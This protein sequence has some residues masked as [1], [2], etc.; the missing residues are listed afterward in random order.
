M[1]PT[2]STL[3]GDLVGETADGVRAA[4]LAAAR[5][6]AELADGLARAP[7]D[8][9]I[10]EALAALFPPLRAPPVDLLARMLDDERLDAV[11]STWRPGETAVRAGAVYLHPELADGTVAEFPPIEREL[12]VSVLET[13]E[14]GDGVA[15]LTKESVAVVRQAVR[16]RLETDR[17]SVEAAFADGVPTPVVE[18]TTVEAKAAFGDG[19][20]GIEASLP[21]D[22]TSHS[23]RLGSVRADLRFVSLPL[24]REDYGGEEPGDGPGPDR[25][26]RPAGR[27]FRPTVTSGRPQ[28]RRRGTDATHRR[29][30]RG[31]RR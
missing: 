7:T 19:A 11:V 13:V 17:R 24:E 23:E 18:S 9:E 30:D 14:R 8:A 26:W 21:G 4:S 15:R 1:S 6:R 3:V 5:R 16:E 12:G 25:P 27:P 10:D 22:G 28:P 29:E 2:L 20:D 31:G